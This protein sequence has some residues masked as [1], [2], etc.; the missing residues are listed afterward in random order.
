MKPLAALLLAGSLALSDAALAQAARQ[1]PAGGGDFAASAM[2]PRFELRAERGQLVREVVTLGNES[3]FAATYAVRTADWDLSEAG[4]PLFYD[5]LRPGSC[6]PWVRIERRE[7]RLAPRDVRRYRFEVHVP[8]EAA[9]GE[10]RFALMI[11]QPEDAA[12]AAA[13]AGDI[14]LPIQARLGIV[15]YLRIGAA[16]PKL[17]LTALRADTVN[18]RRI[19]VAVFRNAGNA[20]GRPA[21]VLE[22]V[23]ADRRT[24]EF[25][26]APAPILP[27]RTRTIPIW[28]LADLQTDRLPEFRFPL[29]LKGRIEWEGGAQDVDI[30]LR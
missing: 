3:S 4:G 1:R 12:A 24:L 20:H 10:C 19:P 17:E 2:P 18:A 8:P 16:R 27:G 11:E 6:R 5:E 14:R 13:A 29:S 26:V 30:V 15:V 23:D 28:P 9:E 21:G 7:V 25:N 22:A